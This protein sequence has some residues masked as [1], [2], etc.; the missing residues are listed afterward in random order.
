MMMHHALQVAAEKRCY[1]AVLSSNL[2]R[3]RAQAF[4][5]ALGFDRHGYSF[6]VIAQQEVGA[7]G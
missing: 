2:K 6:R 1:K 7:D 5:E 4:Y 3:E